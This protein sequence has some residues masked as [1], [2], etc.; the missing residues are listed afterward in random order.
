MIQR[1]CLDDSNC[2]GNGMWRRR[3]MKWRS[4]G[5]GMVSIK[6]GG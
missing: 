2:T 6:S 5:M 3:V 4:S 1:M